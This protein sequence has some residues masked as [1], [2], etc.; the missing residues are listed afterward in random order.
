MT[1]IIFALDYDDLGK[2]REKVRELKEELNFFK[3]GY[4]LFTRY[5]PKAVEMVKEEGQNVFLDLKLHDI[6]HI[7][8]AATKNAAE[9]GCYSLTIH[10]QAGTEALKY[11]KEAQVEGFPHLWGVTVLSSIA[12]GNS[13]Q[14]ARTAAE[15]NIEGVIVSGKDV[16]ETKTKFPALEVVVPGIRPSSYITK[17]DQKRILTPSQ[18]TEK[19]ADFLVI[20]RPI[21]ESK[22]PIETVRKIKQEIKDT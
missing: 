10:I 6:P 16:E 21:R 4:Q 7:C 3:I 13:I 18:A 12:E 19:G 20:G 14:R 2:A 5:G 15:C 9:T 22:D 17:D 11:A 1:Q 8:A